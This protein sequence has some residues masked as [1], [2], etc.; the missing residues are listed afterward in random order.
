MELGN[1]ECIRQIQH[2]PSHAGRA[3]VLQE[4]TGRQIWRPLEVFVPVWFTGARRSPPR[5]RRRRSRFLDEVTDPIGEQFDLIDEGYDILLDTGV[6]I[7]PWVFAQASLADPKHYPAT[8]LVTT[9]RREG[10]RI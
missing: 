5:Q 8:H 10:V 9:I 1:A 4:V 3:E 2:R 6:N 7:Q